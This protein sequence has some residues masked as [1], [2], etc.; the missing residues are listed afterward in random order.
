MTA[1]DIGRVAEIEHVSFPTTWPKSSYKR[2]LEQNRLA[3]Y[4]VAVEPLPVVESSL[5]H[6]HTGLGGLLRRLVL[7]PPEEPP[8]E[9]ITGFLG[10]WYMV[11]EAHIVTVAVDPADRRRGLGELLV[12]HAIELARE[13]GEETVTLEC[14]V[15]N[16]PALAL[17]EKYGFDRAG[18]RR[19]Y[20]TDNNE[21]AVIMTTPRLD[22]AAYVAHVQSLRDAWTARYGAVQVDGG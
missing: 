16:A 2:E 5:V 1:A 22:D 10:L 12:V 20:Y 8:T 4:I 6:E 18:I 3:R 14:R 21:D 19:R 11:G 7:A 17:Y 13:H 9:R 15:S